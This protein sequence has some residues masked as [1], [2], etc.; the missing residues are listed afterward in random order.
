VL[1]ITWDRSD[2]PACRTRGHGLLYPCKW[3][4][5]L[6]LNILSAWILCNWNHLQNWTSQ[7]LS[8]QSNSCTKCTYL[9]P[10]KFVTLR[11]S[12][13][14]SLGV[15]FQM[16][17]SSLIV[18]ASLWL[19]QVQVYCFHR[20]FKISADMFVNCWNCSWSPEIL[21]KFDQQNA[22]QVIVCWDDR[23][24]ILELSVVG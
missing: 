24:E 4:H 19:W 5:T 7:S 6:S 12:A 14:P 1:S 2:Y 11:Y 3:K 10:V 13:Y 8:S 22:I 15:Q 9:V 18:M 17:S 21:N 16:P 20:Q 23:S